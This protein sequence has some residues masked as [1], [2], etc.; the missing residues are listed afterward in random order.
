MLQWIA[1]NRNKRQPAILSAISFA[2]A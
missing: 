1:A 2:L